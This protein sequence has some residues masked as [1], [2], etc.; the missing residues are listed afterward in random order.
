MAQRRVHPVTRLAVIHL[1]TSSRSLTNRRSSNPTLTATLVT[2][3]IAPH[4]QFALTP[5]VAPAEQRGCGVTPDLA[6]LCWGKAMPVWPMP[7][8]LR[9]SAVEIGESQMCAIRTDTGPS[10]GLTACWGSASGHASSSD[11]VF[12]QVPATAFSDV[13]CGCTL[14]ASQG[15]ALAAAVWRCG[16]C[17]D[18]TLPVR[19]RPDCDWPDVRVRHSG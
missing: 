10:Q 4:S 19:G 5:G 16:C 18:L 9:A 3:R 2:Q 6:P 15:G 7:V 14:G 13:R 17:A 8:G 12:T 11:V 1:G